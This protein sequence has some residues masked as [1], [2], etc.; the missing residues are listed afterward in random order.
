M[1]LK[2]AFVGLRTALS[3]DA[4][5]QRPRFPWLLGLFYP[6]LSLLLPVRLLLAFSVPSGALSFPSCAFSLAAC[7]PSR[8][9]S[10]IFS[11]FVL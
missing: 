7:A 3:E 2:R 4:R 10:V 5:Q 9:F 1:T 8:A 11:P 6:V